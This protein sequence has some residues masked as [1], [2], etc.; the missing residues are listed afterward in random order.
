MDSTLEKLLSK[1]PS[2]NL[3]D[4]HMPDSIKVRMIKG[5][6]RVVVKG[7]C[8]VLGQD[9][10]WQTVNVRTGKALPFELS[11]RCRLQC[12]LGYEARSWWADPKNAGTTMWRS[13][14][15]QAYNLVIDKKKTTT[16][17]TTTITDPATTN[18]NVPTTIM[19]VG[20]TDT[21][22]STLATY[23]A[24]TSIMQGL[25][26]GVIDGDIGQGDLAPPTS[27]GATILSRQVVDL[28]DASDVS[29]SSSSSG[30]DNV[31]SSGS[32]LFEFVGCISPSG[33]EEAVARKLKSILE[34]ISLL[35][36]ICI[37]NTDGYVSDD[38]G[39]QYKAMIAE[40]LQPDAIICMGEN[41]A[42]FDTLKTGP[43]QFLYAKS[44]SQ[45]YKSR[46]ERLSRRI[47]QFLRYVGNGSSTI[48][49]SQVKFEYMGKLFW[50]TD[51]F[52][53]PPSVK[54]LNPHDMKRMFVGLGLNGKVVGFGIIMNIIPSNSIIQIQTDVRLYDTIYLSNVQLS[55]GGGSSDN[56]TMIKETRIT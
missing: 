37:V 2:S 35:A 23:L 7:V 6:A 51:L 25:I 30:G 44:S 32:R 3:Q 16:T 29:D 21:G 22:K 50:A 14:A 24:N 53:W 33:F 20:D 40:K 18:T 15:Q 17:T 34:R 38:G 8:H 10:S 27:I 43:W 31:T 28:R 55:G 52:Q 45:A 12:R 1:D 13:L 42:L 26:P 46:F 4:R 47:D 54:Q 56:P 36:D 48:D 19:L 5:P 41:V 11:A 39:I 49:I 9:V